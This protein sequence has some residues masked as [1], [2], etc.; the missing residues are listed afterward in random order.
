MIMVQAYKI[1]IDSAEA[2]YDCKM[3][4]GK[5]SGNGLDNRPYTFLM[6]ENGRI[7]LDQV[8]FKRQIMEDYAISVIKRN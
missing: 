7:C 2:R 8:Y 5:I 4:T 6:F 3:C 1:V